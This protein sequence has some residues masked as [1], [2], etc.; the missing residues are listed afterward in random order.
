MISDE[1]GSADTAG[2]KSPW[3][4][5]GFIA[6]AGVVAVIV[7]LGVIVAFSGG[8]KDAQETPA[9]QAPPSAGEPAPTAAASDSACGLEPG[10]QEIP[11]SAPAATWKLR[12]TVAVPVAKDTAGPQRFKSGV[13][14]CFAHSPTGALFA[15]INIYAAL[16]ALAA[17]PPR[18]PAA[19]FAQMIA[20]GP[21]RDSLT[22]HADDY[23]P[24]AQ[25]ASA[26]VQVAGF[27]IVR[28]ERDS[29]VVDLAFRVDRPNVTGYVHA[30][31]TM[32]WEDADWKLV[33]SQSGRPFDS[34][35]QIPDLNGYVPWSGV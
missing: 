6:A 31:S 12:G 19:A 13:P 27:N 35:Q 15:N 30:T 33:L 28:Y 10:S 2:N 17:D 29:A 22:E 26:G 21:G 5:P 8:S 1:S 7:L 16:S 18:D 3:I 20:S 32:R 24:G 23:K 34:L 25:D 9:A 11:A 14:S 4:Q